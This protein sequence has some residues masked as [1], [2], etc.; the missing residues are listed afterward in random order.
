MVNCPICEGSAG[1]KTKAVER[2]AHENGSAA[3][4]VN[5]CPMPSCGCAAA[6]QLAQGI[7]LE[8]VN[9]NRP[10]VRVKVV[11]DDVLGVERSLPASTRTRCESPHTLSAGRG[12]CTPQNIRAKKSCA[13]SCAAAGSKQP[14]RSVCPHH[15]CH[16]RP[17]TSGTGGRCRPRSPRGP[18]CSS[19]T[20]P[21][22]PPWR[23]RWPSCGTP[24]RRRAER[25]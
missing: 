18:R 7:H 12:G 24:G 9:V 1:D 15:R 8:P 17:R 14:Q 19:C 5:A 10:L 13:G 16:R 6:L 2:Y 11:V 3:K 22:R 21:R 20:S 23:A 25:G 4:H